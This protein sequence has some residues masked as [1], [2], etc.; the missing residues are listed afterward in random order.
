M[1][2]YT[3]H[4]RHHLGGP[5][6]VLIKEGFCWPAFVLSVF[7]ALWH[8][9]WLIAL[10]LV[11]VP[12]ALGAAGLWLGLDPI[13]E[14]ALSIGLALLTGYFANDIRRWML[15]RRGYSEEGVVIGDNQDE[16]LR[17]FLT[18]A[19]IMTGGLRP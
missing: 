16:A 7:W 14:S 11:V 6:F 8:R 4:F 19:P 3:V 1:R 12:L 9:L 18:E 5:E 13:G 2:V 10:L 17:R 15:D